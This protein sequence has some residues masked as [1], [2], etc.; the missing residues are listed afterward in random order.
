[1]QTPS[2]NWYQNKRIGGLWRFAIAISILNILGHTVL[3]FEQAWAH[4]ILALAVAY[5]MELSLEAIDAWAQHRPA[6]FRGSPRNFTEFLLSAHITGLAVSMLLYANE[7]FW[8]TAFSVAVAI[9]SKALFRAPMVISGLPASQWPRHH[10]LNPSNFGISVT[11]LAFPWVGIA[12]PYHFTENV[13]GPFDVILPL[14]IF[15]SGSFLNTKFTERIPLIMAWLGGFVLQAA[16]RSWWHATPVAAALLPMSGLAF[17]LFTFYMVTD[18]GTTPSRPRPQLIFGASVA[19]TYG[20]LVTFHV[21]FGLF[22]AL[23]IVT[24]GRGAVMYLVAWRTASAGPGVAIVT[25][26]TPSQLSLR[27]RA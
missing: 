6:R 27:S 19:L 24:L 21:V 9:T 15:V 13:R 8:V 18:P 20:L 16:L 17:V 23:S 25:A 7:R 26:P 12:P 2:D 4:P 1:M 22:F 3:G 11:L 5:A 10:F 14:L